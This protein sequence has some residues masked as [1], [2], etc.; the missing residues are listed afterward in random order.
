MSSSYNLA[1]CFYIVNVIL[2]PPPLQ[3]ITA[4]VAIA[5]SDP[6]IL[7]SMEGAASATAP[8]GRPVSLSDSLPVPTPLPSLHHTPMPPHHPSLPVP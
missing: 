7:R 2:P 6:H 1:V 4:S 8:T 5:A 3:R